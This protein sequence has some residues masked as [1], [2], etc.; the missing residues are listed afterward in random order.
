MKT[1]TRKCPRT[2]QEGN[3]MPNLSLSTFKDNLFESFEFNPIYRLLF[4]SLIVSFFNLKKK[5][6]IIELSI[7][8]FAKKK[9]LFE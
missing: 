5:R 3:K 8:L 4:P 1:D 7:V 2:R 6:K 9:K